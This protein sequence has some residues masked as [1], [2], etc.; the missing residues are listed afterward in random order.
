MIDMPN[1]PNNLNNQNSGNLNDTDEKKYQDIPTTF[2]RPIEEVQNQQEELIKN[3]EATKNKEMNEPEI[4]YS[5]EV[6]ALEKKL[7]QKKYSMPLL[8]VLVIVILVNVV[9]FLG[10]QLLIVP[11]YEEYVSQSEEIWENYNVL[12]S[13]VDAIVGE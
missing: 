3:Y 2:F 5:S 12:K 8:G 1:D 6:R 13:R 11:K 9:W 10:V 4:D 7:N